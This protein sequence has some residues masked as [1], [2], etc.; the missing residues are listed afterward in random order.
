MLHGGSTHI[1]EGIW[2]YAVHEDVVNGVEVEAFFDFC[3]W[4]EKYM[5][6]GSEEE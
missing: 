3:V 2:V 1:V 5:C 4:G 6:A